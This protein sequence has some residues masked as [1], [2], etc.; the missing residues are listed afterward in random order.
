MNQANRLGRRDLLKLGAIGAL[1]LTTI[2]TRWLWQI[3][4]AE[5]AIAAPL[6]PDAALQK[7][8]EG[9]QR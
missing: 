1:G 6:S 7:L 9:N 8:L 3:E 2:A 5:A 4:Q